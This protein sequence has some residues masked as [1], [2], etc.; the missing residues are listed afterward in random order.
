VRAGL[1]RFVAETQADELMIVS[2]IFNPAARRRSIELIA[3]AAGL[4]PRTFT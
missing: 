4:E 2:A 1:Q 3:S